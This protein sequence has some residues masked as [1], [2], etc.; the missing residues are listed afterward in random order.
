M[1][2]NYMFFVEM[3]LVATVQNLIN[4]EIKTRSVAERVIRIIF[5]YITENRRM[6]PGLVEIFL[7]EQD[8]IYFAVYDLKESPQRALAILRVNES[9]LTENVEI[10]ITQ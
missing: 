3:S 9:K 7:S 1:K 10:S 2:S 8:I 4:G 5:R 6:L